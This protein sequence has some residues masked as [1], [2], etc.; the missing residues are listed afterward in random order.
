MNPANIALMAAFAAC[1]A[2]SAQA[3][4][5]SV[6]QPITIG[7][8][9][10]IASAALKE[11][12]TINLVLPASYAR[13]PNRRYPVIYLIDGGVEQDLLHVAGAAQLGGIWGRSKEAIV[14]GIET[15]D[16]RKE[17]V[18]T[19]H[20]PEL[21]KKYPTAGNSAS[22]RKFLREEVK[23][24]IERTYRTGG[25]DVVIGESLAGLFIVETY[26]SD[27]QL[28]DGYAAIDPSLWW[29][30]EALSQ[31][32]AAKI[33]EAQKGRTLYLAMAKEQAE[34]PAAIGRIVAELEGNGQLGW[35][36]ADRPDLT[37]AT[38]YQQLTP[39]ALQ[40]LLPPTEAAPAEFGFEVKCSKK[41]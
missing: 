15:K 12:R 17:L 21:L 29:D 9:Y 20:D 16:R 6:P 35:C 10:S 27:P 40:Y 22:F 26:L 38:I 2:A 34:Q 31:S 36:L 39:Q 33:G 8:S 37:H 24:F 23:P 19:T 32:A 3:Q 14:V 25:D 13:E 18:G 1:V 4:P 41:S 30:K 28:F 7:T 5:A 11:Q